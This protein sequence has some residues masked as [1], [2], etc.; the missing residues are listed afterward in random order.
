ME[1]QTLQ[2]G[3]TPHL[4]INTVS[5]NLQ[6]AGWDRN[7]LTLKS[8]GS[9]LNV[10][11][12]GN[13]FTIVGDSDIILY[14][15]HQAALSI[16]PVLG[17]VDLRGI[18]GQ[19]SVTS[20][21]GDLEGRSLG[22]IEIQQV[23]G[24]V[25]LR[26]IQGDCRL[27]SVGGDA[28]LAHITGQVSV[29]GVAA[30]IALR[31]AQGDVRASAGS[32]VIMYIIPRPEGR[33]T[34]SAGSDILLRLPT[35]ANAALDL[36]AREVRVDTRSFQK[37]SSADENI[38]FGPRQ[39]MLGEGSA[40]IT[41]NAGANITVTSRAEEWA[42]A[43]PESRGEG[44]FFGVPPIPPIPPIPPVPPIPPMPHIPA[45]LNER[46][47]RKME[48]A[49]RKIE[50]ANRRIA[51]QTA[52][53]A[54]AAARRAEQK[55]R[56]AEG[57]GRMA[58]VIG[59]GRKHVDIGFQNGQPAAPRSEPITDEERLTILKMLQEKK[60]SLPEAEKLLAALEGK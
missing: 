14:A 53:R 55:A 39:V 30:D 34:I 20:V 56:A 43:A 24:D 58:F 47:A 49:N 37:A 42:R 38:E 21:S 60:I 57:R 33:Y 16:D 18:S 12:T 3:P 5:G 8:D 23:A 50:E 22:N 4:H 11:E 40:K 13:E 27:L 48:H 36:N 46:I 10:T 17:D 1:R 32:D 26:H 28:S 6:V 7:E 45:N 35:D 9:Q 19:I 59:G 2:C 51:E 15:P 44:D 54:E 31:Q 41:L 52:R 29:D 25:N